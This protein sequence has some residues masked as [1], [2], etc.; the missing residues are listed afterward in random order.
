[1][2]SLKY[3]STFLKS[4]GVSRTVS[5]SYCLVVYDCFV[6]VLLGVNFETAIT[7]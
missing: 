5:I 3:L 6:W 7:I 2:L 4:F 1:M